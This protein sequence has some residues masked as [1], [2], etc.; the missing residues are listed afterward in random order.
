MTRSSCSSDNRWLP[1]KRMTRPVAGGPGST[2]RMILFS[3]TT[4][5]TTVST[6]TSTETIGRR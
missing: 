6:T 5:S 3:P 2:S 4:V 1:V